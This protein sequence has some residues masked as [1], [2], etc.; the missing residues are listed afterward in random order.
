[1]NVDEDKNEI[2]AKY[3]FLPAIIFFVIYV[4]FGKTGFILVADYLDPG[5]GY[6]PVI[7][8]TLFDWII[9]Y[10]L[11]YLVMW[12]LI[13]ITLYV[14]NNRLK[15]FSR[16]G[17]S[18]SISLIVIGSF[19]SGILF[20]LWTEMIFGVNAPYN[21]TWDIQIGVLH[22]YAGDL[23][24]SLGFYISIAACYLVVFFYH[25][26]YDHWFGR[27]AILMMTGVILQASF[28]QDWFWFVFNNAY[29]LSLDIP[30]AVYFN[31]WIW[32]PFTPI[33]IPTFYLI[34]ACVGIL[35]WSFS[36]FKK[37]PLLETRWILVPF[38][39][40]IISGIILG[41]VLHV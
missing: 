20:Y 3:F 21:P 27:R 12:P 8:F 39:I 40:V 13:A 4:I 25:T 11:T 14:Y 36:I 2:P 35:I 32:I 29:Y 30:Y 19:I 5:L 37:Y 23:I 24:A 7:P 31:W 18:T 38:A 34:I 17:L 1:M 33:F 9:Y 26:N 10:V 41:F 16:R 6:P 15:K 28:L 22:I